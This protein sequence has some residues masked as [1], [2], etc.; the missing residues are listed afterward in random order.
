MTPSIMIPEQMRSAQWS[1]VPLESTLRINY[2]TPLPRNAASLPKSSALIKIYSASINPVDYKA[3]EFALTRFAALGKGPWIPSCDYAGIVIATNLAHL[4]L[5]D[6]V[7]GC[8]E[9]PK[10]GTLAEFAV[11]EG[12]ENVCQIPDGV[13]MEDASTIAVAGQTAM[14]CLEP[15]VSKGSKVV[16]NG[17]SGG[18]GTYGIQLAK[19]LGCHVTAICSGRNAELC[20]RLGA[21]EIIDYTTADVLKE[22]QRS[23]TAYDLIVDNITVGGQLYSSAYT[24]LKETGRYATIA[25]GPDMSTIVG[26]LKIMAQPS[27]LGGG[28]RRAVLVGRKSNCEEFIK[29]AGWIRDGKL[30]PVIEKVFD[31]NEAAEAFKRLKSGRTRGK[32]VIRI[33]GEGSAGGK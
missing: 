6:R 9:I 22:L 21:D 24:F 19:I 20:K 10:F 11:V 3:A 4:K 25:A 5:G 17:A 29:L 26:L 8:M 16:V 13:S 14:Q 15:Y 27:C 2:N 18:T 31:L 1:K 33:C 23:G 28:Q 32:I 30:K 12:A 7:A